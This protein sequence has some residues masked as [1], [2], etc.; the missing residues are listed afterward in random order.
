MNTLRNLLKGNGAFSA[1][2][3]MLLLL[4]SP[5]LDGAFGLNAWLL[6]VSGAALIGYGIQLAQLATADDAT[7]GGKFATVMDIA[8]VAGAAVI[9]VGFPTA[10]T[11]AGRI[12]LLVATLAVA[13]FAVGQMR[14]LRR[15]AA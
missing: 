12:A 5:L 3:G 2:S 8:W 11:T 15:L 14:A 10:M 13:G 7:P 9:L 4:G 1:T 6:A